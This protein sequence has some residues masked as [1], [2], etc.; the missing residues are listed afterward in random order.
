MESLIKAGAMDRFGKR[1]GMLRVLDEIKSQGTSLSKSIAAGQGSL[2]A[3][4]ELEKHSASTSHS[5][6]IESIEEAPKEEILSWERELLGFYL[7][8]HPLAKVS[9]KISRVTTSKIGDL[10]TLELEERTVRLGGIVSHVRKTLTKVKKEEMCFA[11]LQDQT[12]SIDLLVFP[13]VYSE[14]KGHLLPDQIVIVSGKLEANEQSPVLIVE[15]ASSLEEALNK[16]QTTNAPLEVS[17]PQETDRILLSKVYSILKESP[18][19]TATYLVLPNSNGSPRKF[20]VPFG[21]ARSHDLVKK[22]ES[23][24]CKII[25]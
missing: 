12:G 8:E 4:E 21:A 24:G 1:N 2:F 23:L 5:Q 18:G 3:E 13:K 15:S 17:L 10:V 20:P 9:D 19:K 14:A 25:G 6:V 22:L 11:K 7:T 16:H